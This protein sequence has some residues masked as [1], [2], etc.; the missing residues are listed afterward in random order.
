M[1]T[2]DQ[3]RDF[4]VVPLVDDLQYFFYFEWFVIFLF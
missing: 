4:G 1:N 3:I 2:C